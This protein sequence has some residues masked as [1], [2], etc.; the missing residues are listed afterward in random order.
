MVNTLRVEISWVLTV[1]TGRR[2]WNI[3]SKSKSYFC[4]V[5]LNLAVT[6]S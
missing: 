2:N 5:L 6:C 4:H 1:E 3:P